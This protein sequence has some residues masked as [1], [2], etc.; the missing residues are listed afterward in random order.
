MPDQVAGHET[1]SGTLAFLFYNLLSNP[2]TYHKAQREVDEVL[3]QEALEAKHLPK[4]K[5]VEAC[6]RET[7][8][9]R[10]PISSFSVQPKQDTVIGGKYRIPKGQGVLC[11]LRGLHHDHQAWGDDAD[12]FR[13]ERMLDG[14]WEK[15]PK[16]A[17]KPFGNG[18]RACI[19]RALAEQEMLINVPLILQRFSVVMA[20]PSYNLSLKATLT[21][22]PDGF[23]IRVRRREGKSLM[24]VLQGAPSAKQ[25][26]ENHPKHDEK[27]RR[28]GVDG[29][30]PLTVAWGSNAGTCKAFA[31]D[32][33]TNAPD[34]GFEAH[35]STLDALAEHVPMD[36]PVIFITPSYEGKPP[37][38]GK[39]F[40]SW[41]EANSDKKLL[42]GVKYC[43]FGAGNSEWSHTF[44]RIPKLVDELVGKM[45][46]QRMLDFSAV[47]VRS[48]AVGPFEDWT[49][50]FWKT[51]RE[52]AGAKGD[53]ETKQLS[54]KIDK[55]ETPV[56][57][58][59]G[60]V[61]IGTVQKNELLA[62][63]E[64]GPAKRHMEVLLSSGMNYQSGK[65]CG[66]SR[67]HSSL[68]MTN[69]RRLPGDSSFQS[70]RT[71]ETCPCTIWASWG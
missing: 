17:W 6:I 65:L 62:G 28:N 2:D 42:E 55:S 18:L 24:V 41:L 16:N 20:D 5:Y 66:T 19:G 12:A 3:G 57:L 1:T 54:V 22:K 10:G 30:K 43:V 49:E 71:S 50:K 64:V 21:I 38:N 45:G 33:Q 46:G 60:E 34:Y 31:E 26:V 67:R 15:L 27:P 56:T 39:K 14:G 23:A 11:N 4:L 70:C 13:P 36:Q 9:F 7:L 52:Q 51:L 63:T 25:T 61:T 29:K 47:D 32:L 53:V 48:D 59:G 69:C 37:D 8:R 44:H 35:L 68:I 40:V 58:T